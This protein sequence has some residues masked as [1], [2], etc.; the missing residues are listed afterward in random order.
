MRF[1]PNNVIL[2]FCFL[3]FTSA[4]TAQKTLTFQPEISD[5]TPNWARLMYQEHPNVWEVDAAYNAFYESN[6]FE[7]STHT[8]YYKKWRRT[9]ESYITEQ[10]FV[11]MPSLEAIRNEEERYR[12]L[13]KGTPAQEKINYP[14]KV[15]GLSRLIAPSQS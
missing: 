4:L 3:L 6:P 8:Q 2:S 1:S 9:I 14:G 13:Y 15:W 5:S 10:G 11:E 7:K 12:T